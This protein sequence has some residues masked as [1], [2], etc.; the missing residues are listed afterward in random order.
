[1]SNTFQSNTT[2][3]QTSTK[4]LTTNASNTTVNPAIFRITG[5]IRVVQLY[6]VITTT[7]GANHT[8]AS[9]RLNDQT[10]QVA[11][12]SNAGTTLSALVAGTFIS[13][14]GLNTAA[15]TASNNAAGVIL[16]PTALETVVFSEFIM[17]KK[18]AANTDIEYKYSTT[19]APTTGVI[20]FF[21]VWQPLSADAAVTPQ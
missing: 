13:K 20:Q 11:I 18:T 4:S 8:A 1:M 21:L 7:L 5:T 10:A 9:W 15:L 6:G 12:T 17:V 3:T 2:A 16:E 14:T 19:D